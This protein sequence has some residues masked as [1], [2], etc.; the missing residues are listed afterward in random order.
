VTSAFT[1]PVSWKNCSATAILIRDAPQEAAALLDRE[2]EINWFPANQ[3]YEAFGG[4]F[5]PEVLAWLRKPSGPKAATYELSQFGEP[6]DL[7]L[8]EQ[9]LATLR[10]LWHERKDEMEDAQPNTPAYSKEPSAVTRLTPI[11]I[12]NLENKSIPY[13]PLSLIHLPAI[14]LL[15]L[16]SVKIRSSVLC[17]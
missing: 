6:Q 12:T 11:S 7:A 13:N 2:P 15:W 9:R 8:L 1:H 14:H 16:T 17:P 3:V 4:R 5:P 10:N